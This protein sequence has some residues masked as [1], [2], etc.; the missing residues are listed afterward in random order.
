MM[1]PRR[2]MMENEDESINKKE[3]MSTKYIAY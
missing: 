2:K 3:K 1:K